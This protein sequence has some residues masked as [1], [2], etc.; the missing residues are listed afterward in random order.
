MR[1]RGG[2]DRGGQWRPGHPGVADRWAASVS[3]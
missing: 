2:A 1:G 3:H